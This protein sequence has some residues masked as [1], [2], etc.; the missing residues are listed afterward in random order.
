MPQQTECTTTFINNLNNP[1]HA[2]Y[3]LLLDCQHQLTYT[4]WPRWHDLMLSRGSHHLCDCNIIVRLLF[5]D[6]YW[7]LVMTTGTLNFVKLR[8]DSFLNKIIL[9]CIVLYHI[10]T[11]FYHFK[12]SMTWRHG[13]WAVSVYGVSVTSA[14]HLHA[15]LN[16]WRTIMHTT[17]LFNSLLQHYNT[18]LAVFCEITINYRESA[19]YRD[20]NPCWLLPHNDNTTSSIWQHTLHATCTMH[21][22]QTFLLQ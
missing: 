1:W 2:L 5:K 3:K 6:S 9:S 22:N 13:Q 14:R 15:K 16:D 7:F 12:D 19:L 21:Q 11:V 20:A 8:L 18:Q 17:N 4:S 10:E